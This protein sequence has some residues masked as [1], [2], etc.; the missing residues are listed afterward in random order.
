[1]LLFCVKIQHLFALTYGALF[2][3]CY[4]ANLIF[5]ENFTFSYL[6]ICFTES[7]HNPDVTKQK[8]KT[9]NKLKKTKHDF[10]LTLMLFTLNKFN[11]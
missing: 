3:V 9:K 6:S 4:T 2:I 1:M 11:L 5:P 7:S 8:Q 10:S